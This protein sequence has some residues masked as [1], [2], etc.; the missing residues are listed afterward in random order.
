MSTYN[1]LTVVDTGPDSGCSGMPFPIDPTTPADT[2][3]YPIALPLGVT[4]TPGADPDVLVP[5]VARWG[6]RI[7]RYTPN[8][9]VTVSAGGIPA[10]FPSV[11]MTESPSRTDETEIVLI[12]YGQQLHTVSGAAAGTSYSL[13][14]GVFN[15]VPKAWEDG[16]DYRPHLLFTGQ[17]ASSDGLGNSATLFFASREES[18]PSTVAT[19]SITG[20]ID[21]ANLT[22]YFETILEGDG[23]AS[24]DSFSLAGSLFWSWDG[25][26]DTATGDYA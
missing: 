3:Y 17:V 11:E 25:K 13:S 16:D 5:S 7:R 1:F 21:G 10:S 8:I 4:T 9:G 12:S 26:F 6:W 20:Q 24:L 14:F 18:L 2:S 19:G 15:D 23:T 22:V